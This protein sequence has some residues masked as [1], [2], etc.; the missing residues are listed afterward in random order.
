M[1]LHIL[2]ILYKSV[3]PSP[4]S[5]ISTINTCTPGK[6]LEVVDELR[7]LMTRVIGPTISA[8]SCLKRLSL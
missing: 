2:I 4:A 3:L 8:A 1:S 7:G 5:F 6:G